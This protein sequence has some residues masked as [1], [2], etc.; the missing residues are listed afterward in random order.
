MLTATTA[1]LA[2]IIF[3]GY[4]VQTATG[5][6]AG[7]ISLTLG[8]HVVGVGDLVLLVLM[9]SLGQCGYIAVRYR[10]SIHWRFLGGWVA[11]FMGAG[12]AAGVYAAGFIDASS[13]P[14]ILGWLILGLSLV[15][16][17]ASLRRRDLSP[18]PI[19][20][21]AAAAA[22]FGAGVMHGVYAMGGPL[23]VYTMGRRALDKEIF[24]STITVVWLVLNIGLVGYYASAG[25]VTGEH[26]EQLGP[27]I[28]AM[29]L[30]VVAGEH[31]FARLR[32]PRFTQLVFAL[33]AVAA[34]AL[35]W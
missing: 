17:Y 18:R 25:R 20:A 30:G 13:L 11:P 28:P 34:V 35:L 19:G 10:G 6:G 26:L 14:V 23:L 32:G 9:L 15:E 2:G 22:L 27:L 29:I 7:L 5:F 4:G 8:A 33:L 21:P 12:T 3:I 16:L 1:V 31:L 24:R